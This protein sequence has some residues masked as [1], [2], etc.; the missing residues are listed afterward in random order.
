MKSFIINS[1]QCKLTGYI[2]C[3][4]LHNVVSVNSLFQQRQLAIFLPTDLPL[5][6]HS[7][8]HSQDQQAQICFEFS[9]P[10]VP[11]YASFKY[12]KMHACNQHLFLSRLISLHHARHACRTIQETKLPDSCFLANKVGLL[13]ALVIP[14]DFQ[15]RSVSS[16]FYSLFYTPL[17]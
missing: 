2:I 5:L 17:L 16:I 7:F 12:F 14:N 11:S 4:K 6:G 1:C 3:S 9:L 13:N 8:I 15:C 10:I